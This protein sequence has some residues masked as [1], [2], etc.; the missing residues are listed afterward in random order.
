M[1]RVFHIAIVLAVTV[2]MVFGCCLHHA[3]G[4]Q[5]ADSPSVQNS[6][7]CGHH[8]HEGGGEPCDHQSGDQGCDDGQCVFTL[9]ESGSAS[10]V[11]IGMNCLPVFCV[12]PALPGMDGINTADTVLHHCGPPISLH[13]LNQVILI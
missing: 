13:L 5:P 12:M 8:G 4:S 3:H 11:T 2:H 1:S 9:P 7:D 10:Q 6:C